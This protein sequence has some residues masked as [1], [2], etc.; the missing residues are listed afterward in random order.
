MT[1]SV[2]MP[3]R[4]RPFYSTRPDILLRMEGLLALIISCIAYRNLYPGRWGFFALLFLVPDISLLG[5][6]FSSPKISAPKVSAA[7]YNAVHS[8]LLPLVLGLLAWERGWALAGQ[9]A[10]IWLSHVSFDRSIGYGLK[11]PYKFRYTHIQSS[12]SAHEPLSVELV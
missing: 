9:L 4:D 7:F 10:L 5:Y 8:Y 2:V 12:A 11:F 1:Y 6:L 3:S